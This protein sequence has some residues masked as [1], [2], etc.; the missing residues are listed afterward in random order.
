MST[1]VALQ[2]GGFV[3]INTVNEALHN[4]GVLVE[5]KNIS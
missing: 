2:I 4:E 1:S 5:P 3:K